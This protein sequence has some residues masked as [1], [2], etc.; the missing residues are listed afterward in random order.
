MIDPEILT[1]IN[2]VYVS[3]AIDLLLEQKDSLSI[4]G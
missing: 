1:N 4:K 2:P 3:F